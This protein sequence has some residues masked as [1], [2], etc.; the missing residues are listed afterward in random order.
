MNT[1]HSKDALNLTVDQMCLKA[2]AQTTEQMLVSRDKP[3]VSVFY[4]RRKWLSCLALMMGMAVGMLLCAHAAGVEYRVL[5]DDNNRPLPGEPPVG[6][7]YNCMG[8]DRGL[9]RDINDTNGTG[10][11]VYSKP[12]GTTY[13]GLLQRTIGSDLWEFLGFWQALGR[14]NSQKNQW[15]PAAVFH[16]LIRPEYQGQ[17]VGAD[18]L[19][20]RIVSPNGY[21]SLTLKLELKGFDNAGGEV[22]RASTN[23]VGRNTLTNGPFP[24]VF[25]LEVNP[26][27]T[28]NVG[29]FNVILDVAWPGDALDVDNLYLRVRVPELPANLEPLLFSLAMLLNNFDDT[30]G[31]VQDRSN[32]PNG[33]FENVTAT[34]KLAKLLAMGIQ[35]NLVDSVGGR[36]AVVQIATTLLTRVPRGPC[37][38]WPHFNQAGG[39][40]RV[41]DT[42]WASGDTAYAILDLMVAL[43]LIGDPAGQ[44]PA[45]Q[46]FL[47]TINWAALYR[48]GQGYSQ[49][50]DS[51]GLPLP[52]TWGGFG[53]ET[54]G[55]NLAALA[56]GGPLGIMDPPPSDNGSGFILH[57]GYPI[58][59]NGVDRWGNDWTVLRPMEAAVQLGWYADPTHANPFLA[60]NG[61]FGLS[62]AECPAAGIATVPR[63]IRLMVWAGA[64]PGQT[65]AGTR[66]WLRT[67]R[68]WWPHWHLPLLQTCGPA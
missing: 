45:C 19:V 39:T 36:T 40:M 47:N 60:T 59:P 32:F 31:M 33:D 52:G 2:H 42:E 20:N 46:S 12:N 28:G 6:W 63:F 37:G 25:S 62:A 41:S 54:M 51:N 49:G 5:V 64:G 56:G 18:V 15:N 9:I 7:F 68:G 55:V 11:A 17:L 67:I 23:F 48:P 24:R 35:N 1:N 44:L 29:L 66:W 14:P 4:R 8:G 50:F 13:R 16:P 43:Q 21:S 65:T 61:L 26:T 10:V 27:N 30:T 3:S 38:L 53:M 22:L 34:A 57:A 58:V